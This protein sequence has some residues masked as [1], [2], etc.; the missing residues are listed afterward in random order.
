MIDKKSGNAVYLG[1]AFRELIN[2]QRN[3]YLYRGSCGACSKTY[4]NIMAPNLVNW[5]GRC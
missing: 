4:Y 5:N 1:A 3:G 2:I